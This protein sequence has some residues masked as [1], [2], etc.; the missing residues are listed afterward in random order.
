MKKIWILAA[1]AG[2]VLTATNIINKENFSTT[3]KIEQ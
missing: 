1:A 2:V 3:E